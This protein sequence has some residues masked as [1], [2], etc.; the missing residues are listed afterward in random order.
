VKINAHYAVRVSSETNLRTADGVFSLLDY[1][2]H[3]LLTRLASEDHAYMNF[4]DRYWPG[5]L[6][7][8]R[9]SG[10]NSL[11]YNYLFND[12]TSDDHTRLI[13]PESIAL[14]PAAV[15]ESLQTLVYSLDISEENLYETSDGLIPWLAEANPIDHLLTAYYFRLMPDL[16]KEILLASFCNAEIASNCEYLEELVANCLHSESK[17]LAQNAASFLCICVGEQGI[18]RLKDILLEECPPHKILIQGIVDIL[19]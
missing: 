14:A 6:V 13:L 3:L 2:K 8:S 19:C 12:S 1:I 4:T 9:F 17:R 11:D 15:L 18:R 5:L 16:G 7:E 10:W